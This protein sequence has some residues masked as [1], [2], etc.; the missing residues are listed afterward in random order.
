MN[1]A[2][3]RRLRLWRELRGRREPDLPH[4]SGQERV[5][6]DHDPQQGRRVAQARQRHR[7]VVRRATMGSNL[8]I[9][10][11]FMLFLAIFWIIFDACCKYYAATYLCSLFNRQVV[12]NML[13]NVDIKTKVA[14]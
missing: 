14:F 11:F 13:L 7:R 8:I 9:L 10:S 5:R 12:P 6:H 1:R 2:Q 3:G 4:Q